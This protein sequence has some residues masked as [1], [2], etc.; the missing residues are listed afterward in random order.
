MLSRAPQIEASPSPEHLAVTYRFD[1]FVLDVPR[2]MLYIGGEA[3]PLSE[4]LFRVLLVLL[5]ADR[6][7][8]AKEDFF[9]QVWPNES[10][11][12]QNL[13]QHIC[14]LRN[15]LRNGGPERS[16]ILSVPGR[17]YRLGAIVE[18]KVGLMMKGTCER[19]SAA[20]TPGGEAFICSYECTF[21]ANCAESMA[22]RCPNC[23]GELTPRPRRE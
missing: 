3:K 9:E 12:D 11:S 4:K 6:G 14:M 7:I 17:G 10:V 8:V 18:K 1:V 20:L 13:T 5:E 21:C 16:L 22:R 2:R 15:A 23:G 19:C